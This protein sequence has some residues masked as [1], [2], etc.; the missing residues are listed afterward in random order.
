MT[1][2]SMIAFSCDRRCNGL[3]LQNSV[4]FLAC[5]V[6]ARVHEYLYSVELSSSRFTAVH[7][8]D[9]FARKAESDIKKKLAKKNEIRP[10]LCV[11][12]ID[13]ETCVHHKRMDQETR[14]FHGSWVYCHIIEDQNQKK[15]LQQQPCVKDQNSNISS[16]DESIDSQSNLGSIFKNHLCRGRVTI[17]TSKNTHSCRPLSVHLLKN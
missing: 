8:V 14:Q 9:R 17:R 10:F 7:A 5:G 3:Q 11:D 4:K 16:S 2:C 15:T 1:V 6:S 13:F 12:N